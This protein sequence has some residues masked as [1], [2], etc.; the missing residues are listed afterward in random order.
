MEPHVKN[1]FQAF[2]YDKSDTILCEH[3]HAVG[4]QIH[5]IEPRS[6]FGSTRKD[7]QDDASNLICL[8]FDCHTKAHGPLS[9]WYKE[10]FKVK[11]K[12]R[13]KELKKTKI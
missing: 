3:C 10:V 4:N 6:S 2:G 8:C 11:V 1:Y 5:H 9:K 7:E 12:E 13:V